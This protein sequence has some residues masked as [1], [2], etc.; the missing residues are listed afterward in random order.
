MVQI[1]VLESGARGLRKR[2]ILRAASLEFRRKGFHNTGM[3]DIAAALE[4][5]VSNLYYYFKNKQEILAFCQ[6]EALSRL[7][8]LADW[9]RGLKL[10]ADARLGLLATGHV[11]CLNEVTPGS[12][13]HLEVEELEASYRSSVMEKRDRYEA[14]LRQLL[15]EGIAQRVFRVT[16]V[17][18]AVL[19]ILGALNWTVKWFRPDGPKSAHSIGRLFAEQLV[20]GLLAPGVK[21]KIPELEIPEL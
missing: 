11:L 2:Q 16:D 7:L 1:R 5:T 9:T 19:A 17:K 21:L 15:E 4:M 14:A 18:I 6:E 3:R 8:A 10:R 13:A 12:L 20:R